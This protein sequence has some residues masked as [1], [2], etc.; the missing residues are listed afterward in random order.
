M[1]KILVSIAILILTIG[2]AG[3]YFYINYSPSNDFIEKITPIT[4][5]KWVKISLDTPN[6][7]PDDYETVNDFLSKIDTHTGSMNFDIQKD[8]FYI[9][10]SLSG[11]M[12]EL[13]RVGTGE[14]KTDFT[15]MSGSQKMQ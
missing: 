15:T 8:D 13:I 4:L 6:I 2:W 5:N 10:H 3:A 7:I 12:T 11:W 1:N 9:M 14:L